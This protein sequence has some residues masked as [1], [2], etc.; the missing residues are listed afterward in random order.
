MKIII[1][2]TVITII[3]LKQAQAQTSCPTGQEATGLVSSGQTG[4]ISNFGNPEGR[5]VADNK[6][7]YVSYNFEDYDSYDDL[8]SKYFDQSTSADK[9]ETTGPIRE[10]ELRSY[11]NS[12]KKLIYVAGNLDINNNSVTGT[13]TAVVFVNGNLNFNQPM[14]QFNYGDTNSGIVF[15]VK[16]DVNIDRNVRLIN[17]IIIS[18]GTI[19][20]AYDFTLNSC[21]NSFVPSPPLEINGSLISLNKDKKIQ[22]KRTLAVNDTPAEKINH[23]AKYL[24][25]LRDLFASPLQKW[26]EI[27]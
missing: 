1:I 18:E 21:P 5:C 10:G 14:T 7:F 23:Q 25:I 2:I 17:A 19:C 4:G 13:N 15:V 16:G 24:V 26:S 9:A 12:G 27:Q 3:F 22:F 11:L 6:A 20:T 8:K